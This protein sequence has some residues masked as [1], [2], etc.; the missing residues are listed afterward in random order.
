MSR[1]RSL[2]WLA[3]AMLIV[4]AGCQKP[5][6]TSSN[7]TPAA[8]T[9]VA[10]AE[11]TEVNGMPV[12]HLKREQKGDGPQFLGMTILPG[13]G[14]NT[15]QITGYFPGLGKFDVLHA[16]TLA[17]AN[18][19]YYG[20]ASDAY[21]DDSF[22]FG[23]AFLVPY[24]N[25]ILGKLSPDK[26]TI[27]TYWHGKKIVLPANWHNSAHPTQ[28]LHAMHGLI[29]RE[30]ASNV[31]VKKTSD[32]EVVTADMPDAFHGQWLSK[33]DL[34]FRIALTA[35]AIDAQITAKN[36][37]KED[38]PLSISWHPYL[39][40]P[41]GQHAQ[42]RLYVPG[43]M[44]AEVN[45]Y[46][47]VFVTGKL[48]PVK[49]TRWDFLDP[50]G[51][52]LGDGYLDD[53]WSHLQ[54]KDGKVT[55]SLMDPASNYEISEVGFSPQIKTIQV[56]SPPSANFAVVEEQFNFADP[57]GKEWHGMNTGMVTL[58]PGQAVMWHVQLRMSEL[59]PIKK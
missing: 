34:H 3:P 17:V 46:Q 50:K 7:T 2:L 27:T 19:K 16:P 59:H 15:F 21:G 48:Q 43:T 41:S 18:T 30:N 8:T 13:R 6:T 33:T 39:S 12:V 10:T 56:Y 24:P 28:D 4:V 55:T 58:K 47:D 40:I 38:E 11:P 1:Y 26:K 29:L 36:V 42:A 25:R 52:P 32:G 22:A 57:F 35:D 20:T 31:Q 37:G 14:M 53:N 9:S 54:W 49:G 5:S 44:R 23:G 45:N 51:T